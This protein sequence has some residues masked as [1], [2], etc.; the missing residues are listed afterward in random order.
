MR[1][2]IEQNDTCK[3]LEQVA[4]AR[5]KRYTRKRAYRLRA[6]RVRGGIEPAHREG[7]RRDTGY[8]KVG[9]PKGTSRVGV[10]EKC[11]QLGGTQV[12]SRAPVV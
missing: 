10:L 3:T 6:G 11:G 1:G 2:N 5:A 8:L 4:K 9:V 7:I 12:L